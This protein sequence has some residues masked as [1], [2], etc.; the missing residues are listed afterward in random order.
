M[1]CE[2]IPGKALMMKSLIL[3]IRTYSDL[4]SLDTFEDRYNY[5]RLNG[6]VGRETFGF[7]RYLNQ[8]FYQSSDWKRARRA[9]IIRDASCDLGIPGHEINSGLIVHH[10]NPMTSED[11]IHGE[12]WI[13]DPEFLICVTERTHNAIHYGDESLL[14]IRFNERKPKDT[15][16]W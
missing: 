11:I 16:L 13:F 1:L 2:I 14:R 4:N 7:D 10:M 9:V 15:K 12:S 6:E 5:L 3:M 8:N